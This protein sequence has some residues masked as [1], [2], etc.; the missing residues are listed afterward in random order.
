MVSHEPHI[1][2]HDV[3]IRLPDKVVNVPR[4]QSSRIRKNTE[5]YVAIR[6]IKKIRTLKNVVESITHADANTSA[7]C[8]R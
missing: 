3:L 1:V 8:L 2:A 5:I 7:V 4:R 6:K